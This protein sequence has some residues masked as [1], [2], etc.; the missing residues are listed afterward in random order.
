MSKS[1]IGKRK[2]CVLMTQALELWRQAQNLLQ[3]SCQ[4]QF[5]KLIF[6]GLG[7]FEPLWRYIFK[8]L[9]WVEKRFHNARLARVMRTVEHTQNEGWNWIK[10]IS[11]VT[12]KIVFIIRNEIESLCLH[13]SMNIDEIHGVMSECGAV[14]T[15]RPASL[16]ERANPVH[17]LCYLFWPQSVWRLVSGIQIIFLRSIL[18][19]AKLLLWKMCFKK[20]KLELWYKDLRMKWGKSPWLMKCKWGLAQTAGCFGMTWVINGS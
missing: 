5:H 13:S 4:I 9:W 15:T 12:I 19:L 7:I 14:L 16:R 17:T 3:N 2:M 10:C 6:S 18:I 8:K 11:F 20:K 1:Y